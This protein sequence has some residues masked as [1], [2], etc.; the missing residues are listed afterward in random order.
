LLGAFYGFEADVRFPYETLEIKTSEGPF[1]FLGKVQ[2]HYIPLSVASMT[3]SE[4]FNSGKWPQLIINIL[5]VAFIPV[6]FNQLHFNLP[7]WRSTATKKLL[8]WYGYRK[9]NLDF[10][11]L[12]WYQPLTTTQIIASTTVPQ[13]YFSSQSEY[14]PC[15]FD[16]DCGGRN[17]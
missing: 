15:S 3:V 14:S 5:R 4:Y 17:Q 12:G 7:I 11:F 9:H 6:L 8:P 10:Y 1:I 13:F 16:T 2:L